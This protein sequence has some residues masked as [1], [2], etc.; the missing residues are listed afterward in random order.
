MEGEASGEVSLG[1]A[2]SIRGTQWNKEAKAARAPGYPQLRQRRRASPRR[3]LL[4]WLFEKQEQ[5]GVREGLK[6]LLLPPC[7][8]VLF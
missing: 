6:Q 5:A 2:V 7:A 1:K 8:V 4:H 3:A